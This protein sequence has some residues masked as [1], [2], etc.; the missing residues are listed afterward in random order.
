[1]LDALPSHVRQ[2]VETLSL[3]PTTLSVWLIGSRAN[4]S[5]NPRSDWDLMVFASTDPA[6]AKG[7]QPGIDIIQVGPSGFYLLEGIAGEH[8]LPFA[9]WE[10]QVIGDGEASYSSWDN[11]GKN[12]S[13]IVAYD[14]PGIRKRFRAVKLWAQQA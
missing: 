5:D 10:W 6:P 14:H 8:L 13:V 9:N 11:P 4:A 2:M 7:R 3:E 1:M 12:S